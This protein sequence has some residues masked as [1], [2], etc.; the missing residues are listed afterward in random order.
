MSDSPCGID[1]QVEKET[2]VL[3][4]AE[5]FYKTDEREYVRHFGKR[6]FFQIWTRREAY[7]KMTGS[8]FWGEIPELVSKDLELIERFD[9]YYISEIE[10]GEGIYCAVCTCDP[11]PYPIILI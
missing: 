5:R 2:D 11:A 6:G 10:I 7:G 3:K 9:D 8:G 1:I 4:I